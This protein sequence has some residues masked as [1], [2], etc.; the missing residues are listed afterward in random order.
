MISPHN[1]KS[2]LLILWAV[3]AVNMYDGVHSSIISELKNSR[4]F[5]G[6]TYEYGYN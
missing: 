2:R 3:G 1:D 6:C 4:Q 5:K